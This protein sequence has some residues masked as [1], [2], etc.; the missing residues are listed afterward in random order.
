MP[1]P[2]HMYSL[3]AMSTLVGTEEFVGTVNRVSAKASLA[4]LRAF[5]LAGLSVPIP[6]QTIVFPTA[7]YTL[8]LTDK[9]NAVGM[10]VATAN[11]VT[12]PPNSSVAF[13]VGS[14]IDVY[15]HGAGA[16]SLAYGAPVV[17]HNANGLTFGVQYAG[18]TLLKL[19]PDEW[20]AF[21]GF[22]GTAASAGGLL[23]VV[24]WLPGSDQLLTAPLTTS[25]DISAP[26]LVT[27]FTVPA[28]GNVLV[29]FNGVCDGG[30]ASNGYYWSVREGSSDI[31]GP[32]WIT[33]QLNS[34]S[35]VRHFLITGLTPGTS[36]TYK[37][38]H[39]YTT[40]GTAPSFRV[41]PTYGPAIMQV[42]AAP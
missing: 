38:G 41:G 39:R 14:R 10:N 4:A 20:I 5:V 11:V 8:A 37:W 18:G 16:T 19:G 7:N 23:A 42:W 3:P 31:A 6:D 9:N 33:F 35:F 22:S 32:S 21:G 28:S 29:T 24:S 2:V 27:T 13:P 30:T 26:N 15:Q 40:S 36:K 12:V 17:V 1:D 34:S 25:A